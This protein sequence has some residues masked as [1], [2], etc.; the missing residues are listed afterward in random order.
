MRISDW[1]SDVCSSDLE[2]AQRAWLQVPLELREDREAHQRHARGETGQTL[3]A[4]GPAGR[5]QGH[6]RSPSLIGSGAVLAPPGGSRYPTNT[7]PPR[8]GLWVSHMPRFA[9]FLVRRLV[10][11]L[12]SYYSH[13]SFS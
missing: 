2:D 9:N 10:V 11:C 4:E 8:P 6:G 1:S 13:F 3:V 12:L 5:L 7:T